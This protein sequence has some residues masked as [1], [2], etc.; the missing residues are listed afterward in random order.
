[1]P[2]TIAAFPEEDGEEAF[3]VEEPL[4]PVVAPAA[5]VVPVV[6]AAPVVGDDAAVVAAPGALEPEAVP[7]KQLVLPPVWTVNAADCA[8]APVPSRRVIPRLV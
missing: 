5:G 3:A 1:M 2:A 4:D 8:D 7:F 6:A